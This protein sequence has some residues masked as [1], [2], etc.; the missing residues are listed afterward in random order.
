MRER[1]ILS[2]VLPAHA[3]LQAILKRIREKFGLPDLGSFSRNL[4]SILLIEK[5]IPWDEIKEEIKSELEADTE[6]FPQAFQ[7]V[8]NILKSKPEALE[9]PQ[10]FSEEL[11]ITPEDI[12]AA[13]VVVLSLLKPLAQAYIQMVEDVSRLLFTYLATGETEDIPLD[14]LGAVYT[15]RIGEEKVVV[16]MA[17][18]LSNPKEIVERFTAEIHRNFGKKRPIIT[19]EFRHTAK[20]LRKRFEGVSLNKL[21]DEYIGDRPSEFTQ[22]RKSPEFRDQRHRLIDRLKKS[23]KRYEKKLLELVGDNSKS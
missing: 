12:Q 17:G 7:P 20:Y 6:F 2:E 19:S 13:S 11:A 3:D 4:T 1:I 10:K 21:A 5:D 14:W 9:D 16:A 15:M 18:Q 22:D 23:L 8:R